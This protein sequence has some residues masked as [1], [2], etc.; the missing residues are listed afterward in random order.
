MPVLKHSCWLTSLPRNACQIFLCWRTKRK[1]LNRGSDSAPAAAQSCGWDS[2]A[3]SALPSGCSRKLVRPQ[4][5]NAP[6][7][8]G[9][10]DV[11]IEW[12]QCTHP[13]MP[14]ELGLGFMTHKHRH[15]WSVIDGRAWVG[16]LNG[17]G[18]VPLHCHFRVICF[19]VANDCV[20]C[21]FRPELRLHTINTFY[22]ECG[23][24]H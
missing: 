2:A 1:I 13:R 7:P 16:L 10:W 24:V 17:A 15:I 21:C 11:S 19:V 8:M 6:S 20:F 14:G 5:Q 22:G 23:Q 18:P 9:C 3:F 4:Q 12:G